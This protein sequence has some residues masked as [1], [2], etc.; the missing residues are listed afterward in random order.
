MTLFV[1]P[2]H[3]GSLTIVLLVT[4]YEIALVKTLHNE[5]IRVFQVYQ[6]IQHVLVQQVLECI[7]DKYLTMLRS[8]IT[9]Q[10]LAKICT[11]VLH[12]FCI[13]GKISP[14]QL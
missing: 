7:E 13:Y 5:V 10:V 1:I 4:Q 3:L 6:L 9:G 8:G 14:Q 11:L 12:L 2:V